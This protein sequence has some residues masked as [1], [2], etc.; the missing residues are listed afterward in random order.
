MN[1]YGSSVTNMLEELKWDTLHNR[2]KQHRLTMYKI[3]N[4]LVGI[5]KAKYLVPAPENRTRVSHTRKHQ[6]LI[7][8]PHIHGMER[9]RG[10]DGESDT[11]QPSNV[12]FTFR[13]IIYKHSKMH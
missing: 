7:L 5:N 12:T 4:E 2:R 1:D 3:E 9:S 11:W 6:P 10:P 8:P 13:T